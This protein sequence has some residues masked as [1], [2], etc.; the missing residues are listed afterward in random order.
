MALKDVDLINNSKKTF[1]LP[2]DQKQRYFFIIEQR[3]Y[4]QIL[5][6]AEF[7]ASHNIIEYSLLIGISKSKDKPSARLS[8][9]EVTS[10]NNNDLSHHEIW[11][12]DRTQN[13]FFGLID[14][15]S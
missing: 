4:K 10:Q 1:D 8:Y 14:I 7:L 6:D 9:E 13:Y 11:S 15:L 12:N 3:I 2:Q 5:A